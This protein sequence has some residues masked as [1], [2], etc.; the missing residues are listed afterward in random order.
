MGEF[1]DT[2][3]NGWYLENSIT[4]RQIKIKD[5]SEMYDIFKGIAPEERK[6]W[7]MKF[8]SFEDLENT[9]VTNDHTEIEMPDGSR[10]V[11]IEDTEFSERRRFPRVKVQLKVI[12]I[13]GRRIFRTFSDNVSLGGLLLHNPPP[14]D[15][16]SNDLKIIIE[17]PDG[18][19]KILT[20]AE[21]VDGTEQKHL[22][23]LY[24]QEND[25]LELGTWLQEYL[26]NISLKA[27]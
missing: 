5:P 10:R 15:Y 2:S 9:Q 1:F 17:N 11:F 27:A 23:F 19:M 4:G 24:M 7:V 18:T 8:G 26:D 16:R 22:K 6:D 21:F 25:R 13:S 20:P 14:R 12:L 3:V